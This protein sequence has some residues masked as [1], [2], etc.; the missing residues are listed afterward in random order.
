MGCALCMNAEG[1][2]MFWYFYHG[3]PETT[4]RSS[5]QRSDKQPS[6]HYWMSLLPDID[7]SVALWCNRKACKATK[8]W[9]SLYTTINIRMWAYWLLGFFHTKLIMIKFIRRK[10]WLA[11]RKGTHESVPE[12]SNMWGET[13]VVPCFVWL[14]FY[15]AWLYHGRLL[16]Q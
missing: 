11:V 10:Y 6:Q 9:Q 13:T 4:C 8:W 14:M 7:K 1:N 5:L 2:G 15:Q 3:L 16:R 12:C